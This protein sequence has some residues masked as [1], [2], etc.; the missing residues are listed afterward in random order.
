MLILGVILIAAGCVL[1][2]LSNRSRAKANAM[3]GTE[4]SRVGDLLDLVDSVR[5]DLGDNQPSGFSDYCELKG[6]IVCNAAITGEF[7]GHSLA[8]VETRVT[9]VFETRREERDDEGHVRTTWSKSSDTLAQNTQTAEFFIDDGSGRVRVRPPTKGVE[10]LELVDRFEP[11]SVVEARAGQL[12]LGNGAFQLSVPTFRAGNSRRLLGYKFTERGL[13]LG[14]RAYALG[15]I[16]DT[17]E[18]LVLRGSDKPEQPFILSLRSEEELVASS[19]RSA[20]W[21]RFGGYIAIMVGIAVTMYS[22][23]D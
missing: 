20:K 6:E 2:V 16:A 19:E 13:P 5:S 21:R 4:T 18:G 10:L 3:A 12:S 17:D 7:S 15:Q 23:V 22:F 8:M 11:P 1:L 9:R 14:R